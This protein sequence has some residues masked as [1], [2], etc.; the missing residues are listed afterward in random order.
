[1]SCT[2]FDNFTK[3]HVIFS[4][5]NPESG[6]IW[7]WHIWLGHNMKV[8]LQV[9]ASQ[10][11]QDDTQDQTVTDGQGSGF[12]DGNPLEEQNTNILTRRQS[13]YADLI[14]YALTVVEDTM[15]QKLS[16]L[17]EAITSTESAC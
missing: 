12:D 6:T 14:A 16:V 17:L 15:V 7:L 10:R 9:E 3:S 5:N 13:G 8:E 1:M 4:L 11:V 2:L